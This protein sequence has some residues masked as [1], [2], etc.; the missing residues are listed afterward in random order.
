MKYLKIFAI[1]VLTIIIYINTCNIVIAENVD[2][3]VLEEN[4]EIK[5]DEKEIKYNQESDYEEPNEAGQAK[6]YQKINL[7]ESNLIQN[8]QIVKDGYYKIV[9][10]LNSTKV[11]EV[12][13]ASEENSANVQIYKDSN[14]KQQKFQIKHL[15]NNEY[16]IINCKSGK[17]LDVAWGGTTN[18]TNVWQYE[19]N[20]TDAQKWIIQD[21]GN[22]MYSFKSKNSGLYLDVEY[23]SSANGT[24]VQIHQSNGT[25]AQKFKLIQTD[26][27]V[28]QNV[29]QN[30]YYTIASNLD[31]NKVLDISAASKE[32]EANLQI[33]SN[34]KE[35]QQIFKV[36]Y[37]GSGFYTIQNANSKKYLDVAWGGTSNGTN[38]WQHDGNGSSA[39]KWAILSSEEGCYNIVSKCNDLYLDVKNSSTANETNVQV[40]EKKNSK[41]QQFK[42]IPIEVIEGTKSI[43][44]GTYKIQVQ[45]NKNKALDISAGSTVN[46]ANLQIWDYTN[47]LQ[48]KFR[49]DYLGDGFYKITNI[50]SGKV[51]DV[52]G[53]NSADGTNVQQYEWN[54]TDAQKW[55]IR[56]NSDGSYNIISCL[57][58]KFL[59]VQNGNTQNGTNVAIYKKQENDTNGS[60]KFY[61]E[62]VTAVT[63]ETG[64]YGYSGLV[65]KGSSDGSSLKYYKIGNGPNVFFAT[66]AIHGWEDSYS[67]DGQELTKIAEKF[68]DK[69]IQMQDDNLANKWTIY[70][71]PSLNP[72][73]EY[74]GYSHN[75]PGR[76]SLYSSIS[77]H[78][79][80]DLNRCWSTSW[81]KNT[82]NRNYNGTAPFQSYET[83]YL[84]DFLLSK[85]A[86][87]GM[88]VLVDLHGW[89][90]ETIGDEWIGSKYAAEFGFTKYIN[91]YGKGYLVNWARSNLGYGGR[92]ARSAL[93]ELPMVSNSRQVEERKYAEKYI[94]ATITMLR[95]MW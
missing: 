34:V 11:L 41:S 70:I 24:N 26:C 82:N 55:V 33:Y 92:V 54:G 32:N 51:L 69:L 14:E 78:K 39:Q 53:G 4:N 38:V 7:N 73:G 48:Q 87:S 43:E 79:G 35:K 23:G 45:S 64:T 57:K 56:K 10:A 91:T 52:A 59:T 67:Y 77:S 71:F 95:E 62:K 29:I 94:N 31:L 6:E 89:L 85:R 37:A 13:G 42:F 8:T 1:S 16:E 36:E 84:R 66:F 60:Q 72:D 27:V 50:R 65:K 18:C 86:T 2:N 28:G 74:H 9:T 83:Q 81:V 22:G 30:G 75:G 40:Y 80:M 17:A 68:K 61:F 76:C 90:D 21:A 47:E 58:D 19:E 46:G 3:I 12:K 88:T 49:L 44:N 20:G 63:L 15:G 25:N 93:I 5:E